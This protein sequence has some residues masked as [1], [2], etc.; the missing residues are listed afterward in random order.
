MG[1]SG[2]WQQRSNLA[3]CSRLSCMLQRS[4]ASYVKLI[5]APWMWNMPVGNVKHANPGRL[6]I[7]S[8]RLSR[9]KRDLGYLHS[10]GGWCVR[11][12]R[13]PC[14][15]LDMPC[16]LRVRVITSSPT[17]PSQQTG[18]AVPHTRSDPGCHRYRLAAQIHLTRLWTPM[19]TYISRSD[20]PIL[21]PHTFSNWIFCHAVPQLAPRNQTF[22]AVA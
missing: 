17:Y 7:G 1:L 6:M 22:I 12:G 15:S 18:P 14:P 20:H 3:A 9:W 10:K 19:R 2:P 21:G 4:S 5:G 16:T 11:M 13:H 8:D